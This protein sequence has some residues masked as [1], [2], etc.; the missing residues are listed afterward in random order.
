LAKE[1]TMFRTMSN[2][3]LLAGVLLVVIVGSV[4]LAQTVNIN[5]HKIVLNAQGVSDDV[6]ANI[7]IKLTSAR[8]PVYD[9]ELF[10][11]TTKV[12]D[13]ESARYCL[14][15]HILI[16][17]FDHAELLANPD[18]IAMANTTVTATVVGT[19]TDDNGVT[20]EISGSDIVEIVA[21]R[22]KP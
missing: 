12:A 13:A 1:M 10:F 14:I 11:G 2:R 4:C 16:I 8:I 19:V 18:V 6:Q 22:K 5:P 17:G 3:V 9:V 20:K 21:P 7:S 15:D